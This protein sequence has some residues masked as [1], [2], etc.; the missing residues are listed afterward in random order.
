LEERDCP[1]ILVHTSTHGS[2]AQKRLSMRNV[3]ISSNLMLAVKYYN[4]LTIN[5]T[6]Q[7]A[8]RARKKA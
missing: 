2:K 4:F 5:A 7:K 1:L 3:D 6:S 8:H